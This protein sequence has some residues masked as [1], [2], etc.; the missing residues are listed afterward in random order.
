MQ[1]K[2]F[3]LISQH[4]RKTIIIDTTDYL[5]EKHSDIELAEQ[6]QNVTATSCECMQHLHQGSNDCLDPNQTFPTTQ[7]ITLHQTYL[8]PCKPA[9]NGCS[10]YCQRN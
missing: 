10:T 4:E 9:G 2:V 7:P 1:Q 3:D 6:R 5:K 8:L